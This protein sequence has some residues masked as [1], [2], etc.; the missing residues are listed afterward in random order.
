MSGVKKAEASPQR[1]QKGPKTGTCERQVRV[2]SSGLKLQGREHLCHLGN[3][4]CGKTRDRSVG[5]DM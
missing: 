1:K 4:T 3:G 5:L 2:S